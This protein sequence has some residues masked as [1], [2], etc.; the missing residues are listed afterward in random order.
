MVAMPKGWDSHVLSVGQAEREAG[1]FR[2]S[3]VFASALPGEEVAPLL[4]SLGG[5]RFVLSLLFKHSSFDTNPGSQP[6]WVRPGT[7]WEWLAGTWG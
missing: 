7:C 6:R 4:K 2:D 5:C 1:S 3:S